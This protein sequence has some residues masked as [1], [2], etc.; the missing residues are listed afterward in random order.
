MISLTDDVLG[1]LI[2]M[3]FD[4]DGIYS[5]PLLLTCHKIKGIT[6]IVINNKL[7]DNYKIIIRNNTL[8]N[9]LPSY[10]NI[11]KIYKNKFTLNDKKLNDLISLLVKSNNNELLE[12]LRK[13]IPNTINSDKIETKSLNVS[14]ECI[15]DNIDKSL[16][17]KYFYEQECIIINKET[18]VYLLKNY[19]NDIIQFKTFIASLIYPNSIY[20]NILKLFCVINDDINILKILLNKSNIYDFIQFSKTFSSIKIIAY[21]QSNDLYNH[22]MKHADY[23]GINA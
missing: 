7:K 13:T 6:N 19:Y 12:I 10:N 8:L 4:D 9:P 11:Y 2:K 14:L 3:I 21:I 20:E 22:Y 18:I 15:N 5:L 17:S 16:L 23:I 1:Y